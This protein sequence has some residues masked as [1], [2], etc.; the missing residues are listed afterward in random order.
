MRS[1]LSLRFLFLRSSTAVS[2]VLTGLL[3]TF[4]FARVLSPEQFSLFVLVGAIGFTL[5]LCDLGATKILF[6]RLRQRHLDQSQEDSVAAQTSAIVTLYIALALVGAVLCFFA[7][8]WLRPESWLQSLQFA[9]F[10][11]FTALNLAW[12][13]LRNIAV[14]VDQYVYFETLEVTRRFLTIFATAAMLLFL[15][16]TAFLILINL[17]WIV[18]LTMCIRR[19]T[20]YGALTTRLRGQVQHLRHFWH[21]NGRMLLRSSIFSVS[22]IYIY[23]FPYFFV[24]AFYG[25][26]APTIILDTAFKVF[27]GGSVAYSAACDIALPRQTQAFKERDLPALIR[28]TLIALGLCAIPTIGASLILLIA[29]K[30]LFAFL[31][32]PAAVMPDVVP[33]LIVLLVANMIQMVALSLLVH[34]GFFKEIAQAALVVVVAMTLGALFAFVA[35]LSI[36]DYMWI[37]AII[38]SCGALIYVW[39]AWRGPIHIAQH[40]VPYAARKQ[41]HA[42]E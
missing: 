31:L 3:Q 38:Y 35:K 16:V 4:V 22:E 27:R 36:V 24:P 5:L 26:G 17:M 1:F 29:G 11:V 37:Y 32:G 39:L 40:N 6:V 18:V 13:A 34:T 10:F 20:A 23:N 15:P 7:M 25:L 42:A 12:F 8:S 30:Q 21:E 41:T 19:L 33:I 14:A 2:S 28:S 9:L